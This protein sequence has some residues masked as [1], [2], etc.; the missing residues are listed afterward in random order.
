MNSLKDLLSHLTFRKA[1]KLLGAEGER[2]IRTG[3]RY[4]VDIDAQAT[5][6][7]DA[8]RFLMGSTL[9]TI[10]LDNAAEQSLCVRCA[11][12]AEPCVHQ[13]AALSLILEDKTALGLAAP[14]P[15]RAPVES[16]TGEELI[17]QAIRS[18]G[19]GRQ[20][21]RCGSPPRTP[22]PSGPKSGNEP[23]FG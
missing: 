3:G 1:C 17:Q 7:D 19:S 23:Q 18:A 5:F 22:I 20:V 12:C 6:H 14:P 11:K 13:G 9:V 21:R 2:L 4:D 10:T 8:F 16:L 15:Q